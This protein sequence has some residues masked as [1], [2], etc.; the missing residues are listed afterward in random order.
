LPVA[1]CLLPVACCLLPVACC[2]LPGSLLKNAAGVFK[3]EL[4]VFCGAAFAL[5]VKILPKKLK[6]VKR[7]GAA[8]TGKHS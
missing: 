1:C 3:P 5:M 7:A 4:Y 2:L 8:D 6:Y